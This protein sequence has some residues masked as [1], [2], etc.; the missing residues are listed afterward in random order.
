M[1]WR[2]KPQPEATHTPRMSVFST[3]LGALLDQPT[4]DKPAIVR[5]AVGTVGAM[6]SAKLTPDAMYVQAMPDA[7]FF[8][9]ASQ[10]FIGYQSAAI[11]AQNWLVDK[12]CLDASAGCYPARIRNKRI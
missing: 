9:Y 2:K 5:Q 11:I 4:I 3:D 8:W 7:Q 12:A 6:D 1:F 10:S